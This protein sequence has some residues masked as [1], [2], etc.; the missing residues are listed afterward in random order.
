MEG[1]VRKPRRARDPNQVNI[2]VP[3]S[4]SSL[5]S[6]TNEGETRPSGKHNNQSKSFNQ[7]SSNS[8]T[9]NS[10][11]ESTAF[12]VEMN[13]VST[14]PHFLTSLSPMSIL[15]A[16]RVD[17]FA[18]YPIQM[19]REEEWL[20]DQSKFCVRTQCSSTKRQIRVTNNLPK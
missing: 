17:P 7:S 13:K 12:S 2:Y 3:P 9:T 8:L 10:S 11:M 15:G 18:N 20:I 6:A 4:F 5:P 19:N 14:M 16:G 1:L